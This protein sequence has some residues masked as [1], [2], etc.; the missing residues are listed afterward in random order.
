MPTEAT[1]Q[2]DVAPGNETGIYYITICNVS[3][4]LCSI[5]VLSQHL[6]ILIVTLRNIMAAVERLD[7]NRM[8]C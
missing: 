8:R 7:T 3:Y 4:W 6:T 5:S 1:I 2:A